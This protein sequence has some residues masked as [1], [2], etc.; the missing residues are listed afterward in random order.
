MSWTAW[1]TKA[2]LGATF[3][4]AICALVLAGC[5][6]GAL[7]GIEQSCESSG[8]FLSTD[9]I[10]CSGSAGSAKGSPSLEIVDTDGDLSGT[11]RLRSTLSVG[12]GTMKANVTDADGNQTGGTVSPDQPLEL[13]AIISLDENDDEVSVALKTSGKE[14]KDIVYEATFVPAE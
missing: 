11:Y 6:S 9:R 7:T 4:A 2:S 5:S 14:V 8:G 10:S 13:D 3:G 12:Q 1:P